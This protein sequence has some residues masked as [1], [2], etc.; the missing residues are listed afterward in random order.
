[1]ESADVAGLHSS[2]PIGH[3]SD[4]ARRLEEHNSGQTQSTRNRGP[5]EL[6]HSETFESKSAA[7]TREREIKSWKSAAR[8]RELIVQE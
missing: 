2:E 4:L 8:I 7:Y 3:T 6:A 1:M 5:W